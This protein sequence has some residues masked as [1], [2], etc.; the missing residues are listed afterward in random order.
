MIPP[1]QGG[2]NVDYGFDCNRVSFDGLY[3]AQHD[4]SLARCH[5]ERDF[6][7][8]LSTLAVSPKDKSGLANLGLVY[9]ALK[10]PYNAMPF[11]KVLAVSSAILILCVEC[12]QRVSPRLQICTLLRC[13]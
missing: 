2:K 1:L 7:A 13:S 5:K 9:T 4:I 11:L 6:V 3:K 10:R 12:G 8:S